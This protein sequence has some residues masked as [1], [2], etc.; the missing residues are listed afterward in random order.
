M[1]ALMADVVVG[2]DASYLHVDQNERGSDIA[3]ETIE[4]SCSTTGIDENLNYTKLSFFVSN[5]YVQMDMCAHSSAVC[6]M[7][8]AGGKGRCGHGVR[9]D[10]AI[11]C[12]YRLLKKT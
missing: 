4:C 2:D 9:A 6:G 1:C 11:H 3:C 12:L 8:T 7:K 10:L 5:C